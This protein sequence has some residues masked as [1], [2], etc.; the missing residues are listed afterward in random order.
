MSF[1]EHIEELRTRL[2]QAILG[3]VAACVI[4]FWYGR[5]I[6]SFLYEPLIVVLDIAGLPKQTFTNSTVPGFT[7]YMKVSALAALV[8][9]SPWVVYQGWRFIETGL[10]AA[11]RKAAGF[12][13]V[14][15]A[16]MTT[17]AVLFTYY[18]FIPAAM[19]FLVFWTITYPPPES[20][21]SSVLRSITREF[22]E[23]NDAT[24]FGALGKGSAT[25][26]AAPTSAP[27]L[28]VPLLEKDPEPEARQPGQVWFNQTQNEMRF[29]DGNKIRVLMATPPTL[30]VPL[31]SPE[32]YLN[33]A[34][35]MTLVNVIVFHVPVVLAVLGMT[36]LVDPA[37]FR[38]KRRWVIMGCFVGAVILT[39][40]QD[41]FTNLAL[42]LLMWGLF[43]IGLVIMTYFYNK[44][45]RGLE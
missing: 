20:A 22:V 16:I 40:S 28:T 9:A 41:V 31:T 45:Q 39:P 8:V 14:L 2:I 24:F 34:L 32:N 29:W 7:I 25:Q 4:T 44:R 26:A 23:M 42:P 15:S 43:E 33:E 12:L 5:N 6:I 19:V 17:L 21:S 36:G 37:L 13:M 10:Y 11:E 18:I 38:R 35:V 1:G 30:I 27:A 3:V